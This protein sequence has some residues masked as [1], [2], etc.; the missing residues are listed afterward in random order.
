MPLV[1]L[2]VIDEHSIEVAA[3]PDAVFE[4]VRERFA[5]L[6]SGPLGIAVSRMWGCDPPSG[7]GVAEEQRPRLIVL[8][9]KHR[10]SSYGIVFR[11]TPAPAG[12][13]LSAESHA[14]FPGL[15]GRA[16]RAAVI[17]TGGHVVATRRL[18]RS[19][20]SRASRG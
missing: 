15:S 18:L 1:D 8:T 19:I 14:T 17:G 7:F 12:S 9:G 6:L 10:F 3:E 5:G 11:I 4:A 20:A 16:Y 13:T 2:P